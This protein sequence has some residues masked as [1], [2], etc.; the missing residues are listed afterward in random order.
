MATK[1]EISNARELIDLDVREV[2]I[3]DS[4][5][6][7]REFLTWKSAGGN[8][9]GVFEADDDSSFDIEDVEK[10]SAA[11]NALPDAA[12]A[13][14]E[15]GGKKDEDGKTAPRSL[16]HFPH[17]NATVTDPNDNDSTDKARLR[18]ALARL[19]QTKL[20]ADR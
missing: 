9:M 10:A 14:V 11:I 20:P 5:A 4:P 17:H 13:F 2:S 7:L 18:N 8:P 16:R 6:N 19:N 12:F 3:V 15:A 1:K